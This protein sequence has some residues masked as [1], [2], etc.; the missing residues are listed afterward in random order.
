MNRL[1][2]YACVWGFLLALLF[3]FSAPLADRLWL[4]YLPIHWGVALA[5]G[6]ILIIA[7]VQAFRGFRRAAPTLLITIIGLCLFFTA[8][9]RLGRLAYFQIRKPH[10]ER[11][12]SEAQDSGEIPNGEG[13][14]DG[15]QPTRFAFFWIRG[16]VDNWVGVVYD[17]TG[18][19]MDVNQ[20]SGW[21][22]LRDPRWAEAV[23]LFG[24]TLYKTER[25]EGHWY[26]CWFT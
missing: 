7:A 17:P 9:F 18:I 5:G 20:A 4:L 1:T 24:G 19:V 11:L 3:V 12:L 16:V 8:G 2:I 14:V 21:E 23:A 25:L 26:L 22:D 13:Y 6:T 15:G 10:F